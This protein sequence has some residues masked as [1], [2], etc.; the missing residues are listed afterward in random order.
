M[1]EKGHADLKD[2]LLLFIYFELGARS[3][4]RYLIQNTQIAGAVLIF[5]AIT[6]LSRHLVIDV[7]HVSD[8][9]HLLVVISGSIVLLCG[10]LFVLTY[11]AT[12]Y[13]RPQDDVGRGDEPKQ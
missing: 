1:M 11:T 7:Q 5:I 12:K 9:F 8:D 4:D 2:I 10:A 6:A 13:R 3:D